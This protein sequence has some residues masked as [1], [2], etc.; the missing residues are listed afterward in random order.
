[1]GIYKTGIWETGSII[2][3]REN[4]WSSHAR[5]DWRSLILTFDGE[6]LTLNGTPSSSLTGNAGTGFYNSI[7]YES[8]KTYSYVVSYVSG[9]VTGTGNGIYFSPRGFSNI[10]ISDTNYTNTQIQ[11][12]TVSQDTTESTGY[13]SYGWYTNLTFN[14]LVLKIQVVE[15][16]GSGEVTQAKVFNNKLEANNFIEV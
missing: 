1:M 9:S 12:R 3:A 2:S 16:S 10:T 11:T 7:T 14:N 6:Y 15:G 13:A 4:L 5:K 8:G